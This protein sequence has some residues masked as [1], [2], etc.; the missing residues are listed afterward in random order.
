M[1]L[2]SLE[3]SLR[4]IPMC[5]YAAAYIRRHPEYA[6][7]TKQSMDEWA[8]SLSVWQSKRTYQQFQRGSWR[9]SSQQACITN[10]IA[11]YNWTSG[12]RFKSCWLCKSSGYL[13]QVGGMCN[14]G[15]MEWNEFIATELYGW[16]Y[17]GRSYK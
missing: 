15:C 9:I 11:R 13:W 5:S 7:L 12:R 1:H 14:Q 8:K 4:V 3:K 16:I 17:S 10:K 6:E 2:V